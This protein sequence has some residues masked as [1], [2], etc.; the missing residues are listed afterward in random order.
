MQNIDDDMDELFRRAG[1]KYP[2]NTGQGNWENISKRIS[3]VTEPAVIKKGSNNNNYKKLL[4]LL[5]FVGISSLIGFMVLNPAQNNQQVKISGNAVNKKDSPISTSVSKVNNISTSEIK[6]TNSSVRFI[7]EQELIQQNKRSKSNSTIKVYLP[8]S[9]V[10]NNFINKTTTSFQINTYTNQ[11]IASYQMQAAQELT[12][13]AA[14]QEKINKSIFTEISTGN[15]ASNKRSDDNINIDSTEKNEMPLPAKPAIGKGF[16][17]GL[18]VGAEFNKV[19]SSPFSGVG[20]NSSLAVGYKLNKKFFIETGLSSATKYYYSEGKSF[21]DKSAA[22]PAGMTVNN[23]E[24]R[25][26]VLEI[27]LKVG[28]NFYQNKRTNLFISGGT[29][30]FIM[31]KERNKYNVT[32]NGNPEK[33]EKLYTKNN[34]KL[35]AIISFSAGVEKNISGFLKV[36]V[37]PYLKLPLQGIGVGKLPVTSAGIQIGITGKLK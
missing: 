24:S 32:M 15:H 22:M 2:L 6:K 34:L 29:A 35:P 19:Q 14:H 36:R 33:M 7:E 37:E 31:M 4:L 28:Y 23:L 11:H 8:V 16:Y 9:I 3:V 5:L 30:A 27:P 13:T 12:N 21:D 17:A 1:E 25:C 26:K 18:F 10:E 20:F